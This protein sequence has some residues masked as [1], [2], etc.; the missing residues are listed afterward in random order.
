MFEV[1]GT[2]D[3]EI[4][5]LRSMYDNSRA[6]DPDP[7]EEAPE[8][9]AQAEDKTTELESGTGEEQQEPEEAEVELP[10]GVQ[11]R[12][13]VETAKAARIQSEIDRAVS[14]R[15]AKEAE[16]ANLNGKP[17]AE[18]AKNTEPEKNARPA[19]P[20]PNFDDVTDLDTLEAAKAKH[21]ADLSKYETDLEAWFKAETEQTFD[22][23]YSE[24]QAE[25]N[26]RAWLVKGTQDHGADFPDLVASLETALPE[27]LQ[28]AVSTMDDAAG[29]V[30]YLGRTP[31]ALK[32]LVSKFEANPYAGIAE[33]GKLELKIQS[34]PK[35]AAEE[36]KSKKPEKPLPAP[37]KPVGGGASASTPKVNLEDAKDEVFMAEIGR[38]AK[39]AGKK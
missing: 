23:R 13:A 3:P 2:P 37:L 20:E 10:K 17:G 31:E 12:I 33:L 5:D 36:G 21:R 4:V 7:K 11:R 25:A 8:P 18:P 16:L 28:L 15:K 30:A 29:M 22:K 27:P 9:E 32:T 34:D 24:K 38:M 26:K 19:R 6:G 14:V 39:A 35:Q 1:V